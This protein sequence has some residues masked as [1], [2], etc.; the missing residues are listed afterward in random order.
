MADCEIGLQ[1]VGPGNVVV[2]NNGFF[3]GSIIHGIKGNPVYLVSAAMNS[4]VIIDQLPKDCTAIDI[5]SVFDPYLGRPR[6]S[7]QYT[8]KINKLW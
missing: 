1:L 6:A 8:M 5:G 4:N 2:L 3:E 7:Y